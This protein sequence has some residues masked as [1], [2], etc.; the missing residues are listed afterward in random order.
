MLL[1]YMQAKSC[2]KYKPGWFMLGCI[3]LPCYVLF[4]ETVKSVQDMF[5]WFLVTYSYVCMTKH[6][7]S[8]VAIYSKYEITKC[9]VVKTG[10]SNV[11]WGCLP[12]KH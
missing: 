12:K 8:T 11:I 6:S 4:S 5:I 2:A 10:N 9:R 3:A 7:N 1:M